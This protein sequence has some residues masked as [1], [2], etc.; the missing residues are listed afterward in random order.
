LSRERDFRERGERYVVTPT[1]PPPPPLRS[2][3]PSTPKKSSPLPHSSQSISHPNPSSPL[4]KCLQSPCRPGF[5][6]PVRSQ[7]RRDGRPQRGRSFMDRR[8]SCYVRA[9]PV[10][11][12]GEP[13][14]PRSFIFFVNL[15]FPVDVVAAKIEPKVANV[16]IR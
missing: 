3:A 10:R 15:L 4:S 13:H 2:L 14:S 8:N 16:L 6:A 9:S 5:S 12:T 1:H 11:G 7:T